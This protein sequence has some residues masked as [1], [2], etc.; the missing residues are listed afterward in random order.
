MKCCLLAALM[1]NACAKIASLKMYDD[2]ML[3]ICGIIMRL[4]VVSDN[5]ASTNS[6]NNNLILDIYQYHTQKHTL[7]H[8]TNKTSE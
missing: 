4:I 1:Q 3:Y 6:I 5:I 8:F 2:N 7:K